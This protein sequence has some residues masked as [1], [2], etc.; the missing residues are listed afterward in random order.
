MGILLALLV[1]A[2]SGEVRQLPAVGESLLSG[3][4]SE[5][6]V[7]LPVAQ[8]EKKD[9]EKDKK[10]EG[11]KEKKKSKKEG[12]EKERKDKK[13]KEEDDDKDE[14][15]GKDKEKGKKDND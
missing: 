13:E 15:G 14:K 10:E 6:A 1:S 2:F 12:K 3:A 8:E 9:G 5:W 7:V 4:D 11:E